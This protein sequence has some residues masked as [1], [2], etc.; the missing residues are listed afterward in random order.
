MITK[1]YLRDNRNED[2]LVKVNVATPWNRTSLSSVMIAIDDQLEE[3]L[4]GIPYVADFAP[5]HYEAEKQ[6]FIL[7]VWLDVQDIDFED[8]E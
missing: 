5:N 4:K 6:L 7:D 1:Q 8:E 3:E 2:N